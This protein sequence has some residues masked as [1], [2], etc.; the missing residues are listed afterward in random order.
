VISDSATP[1]SLVHIPQY[2]RL[3]KNWEAAAG[4]RLMPVVIPALIVAGT[5]G[6]KSA[7]DHAISVA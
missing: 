7:Q 1:H 4:E 2:E 6:W 3:A 5:A